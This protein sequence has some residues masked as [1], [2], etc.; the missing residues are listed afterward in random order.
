MVPSRARLV[1]HACPMAPVEGAV[2]EEVKLRGKGL[3][4]TDHVYSPDRVKGARPSNNRTGD[5]NGI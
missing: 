2:L 3:P 4:G 5:P 1:T